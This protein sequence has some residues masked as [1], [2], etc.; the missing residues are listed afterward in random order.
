[1]DLGDTMSFNQAPKTGYT[2]S[3]KSLKAIRRYYALMNQ[4]QKS[5]DDD[6]LSKRIAAELKTQ[7]E[8]NERRSK[9]ESSIPLMDH[10]T[11]TPEPHRLI[12]SPK[13][14]G[15]VFIAPTPTPT[16]AVKSDLAP[17]SVKS[18]KSVHIKTADCV[19][20]I[21]IEGSCCSRMLFF[22]LGFLFGLPVGMFAR[23]V[24]LKV[25][26]WDNARNA[27]GP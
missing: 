14:T 4:K 6:K 23:N 21:C 10:P 1:M 8:A 26:K 16:E 24:I 5:P 2:K 7:Q 11:E 18:L 25:M 22:V 19:P 9:R 12:V 20:D 15:P 3:G 13:E 27:T 17:K